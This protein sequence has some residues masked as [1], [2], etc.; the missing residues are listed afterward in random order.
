MK[1]FTAK[2]FSGDIMEIK[3]KHLLRILEISNKAVTAKTLAEKL[4]ISSRTVM[5]Y[6]FNINS[7]IPG[8]ILSSQN[9]YSLQNSLWKSADLLKQKNFFPQTPDERIN[10]LILK[11]LLNDKNIFIT[12]FAENIHVS[13][14]TIKK[15][16]ATMQKNFKNS[17][18]K[19]FT[20][21]GKIILNGSEQDKRNILSNSINQ[22][23]SYTRLS[24]HELQKIFLTLPVFEI[25]D[26]LMKT[27]DKNNFFVNDSIQVNLIRDILITISR[28]KLL[29]ILDEKICIKLQPITLILIEKIESLCKIKFCENEIQEFQ[30]LIFSY[31][32]PKNFSELSFAELQKIFPTSTNKILE[33]VIDYMQKNLPFLKLDDNF[34]VRFSLNLHNFLR[35]KDCGKITVNPQLEDMKNA[36]PFIFCITK[37]IVLKIAE[38]SRKNFTEDDISYLSV[39]IGL[40]LKKIR[41]NFL[42]KIKCGLLITPYFDFDVD[43]RRDFLKIFGNEIEI[44]GESKTETNLTQIKTA[45]LIFSTV[46]LENNFPTDWIVINPLL[47]EKNIEEISQKIL[48]ER[49]K[50]RKNI[51][52][53]FLS[54]QIFTENVS[55]EIL[56]FGDNWNIFGDIYL[57]IEFVN[58]IEKNILTIHREKNLKK[59]KKQHIKIFLDF[60]FSPTDWE[61][62][63]YIVD[64]LVDYLNNI[65][66]NRKLEMKFGL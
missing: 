12:E 63:F 26:I 23:L 53:K 37:N 2:K 14:E 9:G 15:D 7:V 4:K 44:I 39:H 5:N 21:K 65:S 64:N 10:L 13:A 57:K 60:K 35:R 34:L 54:E 41:K 58:D 48:Q 18:L 29:K 28:I 22:N 27:L 42:E 19:I 51:L 59:F 40:A 11:L 38:F 62:A 55:S 32:L 1:I 46:P 3:Y 61:F 25:H 20:S 52:S 30:R 16:I 24:L 33:K 31:L 6:I 66:S 47:T 43:L 45:Q 50:N 17:S 36:S 56:N 49:Q 8:L